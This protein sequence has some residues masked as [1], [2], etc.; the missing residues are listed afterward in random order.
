MSP[1]LLDRFRR[2][3]TNKTISKPRGESGRGHTKGYLNYEELNSDLVGTT[4]L[5]VYDK[6]WRTD[7]DVRKA[8]QMLIN[9]IIA[10]TWTVEPYGGKEAEDNDREIAN[11]VQWAL[12]GRNKPTWGEHL[13]TA[14]RVAAR[15]GFAP[16]EV[17]WER[18]TWENKPCLT[19]SDLQLRL[20]RTI[21]Q[22]EQKDGE[23]LS[24]T[25]QT[26][27]LER[28]GEVVIPKE[29]LLYYRL[30]AEGDNWEGESLLRPAYKHW[31]YK[32]KLELID[33][34][35]HER[36]AMGIPVGYV[37]STATDDELD[38]F[39][40]ALAN[41]RANEQS[42]ILMPGRHQEYATD[43][44]GWLFEIVTPNSTGQQDIQASL[45]YHSDKISA[46]MIEEFM[47]LG[48]SGI[49]ARATA[50]VQQDPFY[51]YCEAIA[52]YVIESSINEQLIPRLVD[53]NYE[54]EGRY[55][56]LQASLID[57]TSIVELSDYISKLV[58]SGT[59]TPD[60]DLESY[61]RKVADLPEPSQETVEVEGTSEEEAGTNEDPGSDSGESDTETVEEEPEATNLALARQDRELRPWEKL[62]QLD[63]IEVSIL[64]ARER[65][66]QAAAK[67]VV[68]L[69]SKLTT[70]KISE[71]PPAPTKELVDTLANEL[72]SLYLTG[73]ETVQEEL[74]TQKTMMS[75]RPGTVRLE[76]DPEYEDALLADALEQLGSR[77][78]LAATY[79]T[80]QTWQQ[81][82]RARLSGK[83]IASVQAEAELA[84]RSA[85]RAESQQHA[86]AA[87][88]LGRLDQAKTQ[89][90]EIEGARYTSIL[91]GARCNP[92][93]AA[94][95]DVLRD[96][97]DPVRLSRVPPNVA[98][99]GGNRCRCMEFYQLKTEATAEV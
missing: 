26:Y 39:E 83:D 97:N 21:T 80:G 22:W 35:A 52:S 72:E 3:P 73:R 62:M 82:M 67:E 56:R 12:I 92:C 30:G 88:N 51:L 65:F 61:V 41:I 6:M 60:S 90:D 14:L 49:G 58:A 85:L 33:A 28:Q 44:E 32:E 9:P 15:N 81:A 34:M 74:E 10:A 46:A 57:S 37:P 75:D 69:A 27:S 25:Q 23:L 7:A 2:E 1:S 95:D 45:K 93:A 16:F 17:T 38:A 84:A 50:D 79:V 29:D 31:K 19:I 70:G 36:F 87:L 76:T 48:Q 55:P 99:T 24:I 71:T 20:P 47:R 8:L 96:L 42:Y 64:T 59:L 4:G 77:A 78:K 40:S 43:G 18:D 89:E 94:D 86:A 13:F 53:L 68:Q 11:F 91:D 66:E 98:C 63:R 5:R 54:V